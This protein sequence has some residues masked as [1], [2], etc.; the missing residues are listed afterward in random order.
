MVFDTS[1]LCK[2]L[3]IVQQALI[4]PVIRQKCRP[5]G[6]HFLISCSF[7]QQQ[8]ILKEGVCPAG[9]LQPGQVGAHRA[10][11]QHILLIGHGQIVYR[12]EPLEDLFKAQRLRADM[13][14]LLRH[15]VDL[16]NVVVRQ[17]RDVFR[18]LRM[19][20]NKVR[21]PHFFDLLQGLQVPG[22]IIDKPDLIFVQRL[23][24]GEAVREIHHIVRRPV[25]H[26]I[27]EVSGE[28]NGRKALRKTAGRQ[29]LGI[30]PLGHQELVPK[31]PEGIAPV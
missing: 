27:K 12:K 31:L 26:H 17:R 2:M 6:R 19:G 1:P 10:A 4:F 22:H 21:R 14:D 13:E 25:P 30:A 29:L 8:V 18:R 23:P 11:H 7:P 9:I 3:Q 5:I 15:L 24:A 16:G 20:R 28:V